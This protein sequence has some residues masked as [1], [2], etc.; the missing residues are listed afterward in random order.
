MDG[1][2]ILQAALSNATKTIEIVGDGIACVFPPVQTVRHR[3]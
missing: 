1:D 3:V 2:S